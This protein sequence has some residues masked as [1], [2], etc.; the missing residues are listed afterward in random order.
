MFIESD[1]PS[2]KELF[3]RG[4]LAPVKRFASGRIACLMEI[5][6]M[7]YAIVTDLVR[8]GHDNAFYYRTRD[9]ATAAL[10]AWD[11]NGEPAGWWRHPQSGRRR[12]DG[13]PAREYF[14]P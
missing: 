5:N 4:Y 1:G 10:D 6:S 2:D 9:T 3:A 13:D 11:G 7:L 8:G 12:T 14:Q